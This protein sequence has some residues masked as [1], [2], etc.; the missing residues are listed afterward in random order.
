M[1]RVARLHR[2]ALVAVVAWAVA[3]CASSNP[4]TA[5]ALGAADIR[6]LEGTW[7]GT[8]TG[9]DMGSG[10]PATIRIEPSGAYTAQGALISSTGKIEI[11]DGKAEFVAAPTGVTGRAE[12]GAV[13]PG[14]RAGSAVLMDRGDH[15]VLV[16]SGTGPTGPYNFSLNRP[17]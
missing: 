8:V 7:Q 13:P 2:I 15:W 9:A 11:R 10:V 14:A 1:D 5:R 4:G 17:K 6:L 16:G 12:A 3:G